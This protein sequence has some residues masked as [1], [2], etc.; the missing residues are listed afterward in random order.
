[1][2]VSPSKAAMWAHLVW[3]TPILEEGTVPRGKAVFIGNPTSD[4]WRICRRDLLSADVI[5][6]EAN[7]LKEASAVLI[8]VAAIAR[9]CVG[10]LGIRDASGEGHD[11]T[12]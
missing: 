8:D 6:G 9:R 3:R 10:I 2:G 12:A 11:G 1:M 5:F 7:S 4:D